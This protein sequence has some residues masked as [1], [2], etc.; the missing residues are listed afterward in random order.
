MTCLQEYDMN[1]QYS[2]LIGILILSFLLG[3]FLA[4]CGT[5]STS[6]PSGGTD[7][8]SLLQDRCSICHSTSRIT[9]AHKTAAEWTTTVES[10]VSKGAQLN[11]QE[12]QTLIAYLAENYK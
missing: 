6:T 1:K 3:T 10:M 12:Q 8:K 5:G 11:S 2:Y 9:S 7:G 4:S